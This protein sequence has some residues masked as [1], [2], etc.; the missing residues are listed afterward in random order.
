LGRKTFPA[1]EKEGG[2][3][4]ALPKKLGGPFLFI[5]GRGGKEGAGKSAPEQSQIDETKGQSSIEGE[6]KGKDHAVPT[7][8]LWHKRSSSPTLRQ[9]D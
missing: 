1:L 2:R 3:G 6:K 8:T 7:R 9:G 5:L 4:K